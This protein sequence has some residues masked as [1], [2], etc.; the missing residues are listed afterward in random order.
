MNTLKLTALLTIFALCCSCSDSENEMILSSNCNVISSQT[1]YSLESEPYNSDEVA[2]EEFIQNLDSLNL[3]YSDSITIS[4]GG[5]SEITKNA[6]IVAADLVG[7]KAG[8][9]G[10]KWLGSVL[11]AGSGNP[12]VVALGYFGGKKVGSILGY[13]FA[14]ALTKYVLDRSLLESSY[15]M[16][17]GFVADCSLKPSVIQRQRMELDSSLYYDIPEDLITQSDS[18]G[19]YHNLIM[20]EI[21]RN[22][23]NLM[24][25]GEIDADKLYDFIVEYLYLRKIV[26]FEFFY[27]RDIRAGFKDLGQTALNVSWKAYGNGY[28]IEY[29]TSSHSTILKNKYRLDPNTEFPYYRRIN[30]LVINQCCQMQI[31]QIKSYAHELNTLILNSNMSLELKEEALYNCQFSVN[32]SLCWNQN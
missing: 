32:S 15:P 12:V 18:I 27:N 23:H 7:E 11:C 16:I 2:F 5:G 9:Y 10:G 19:Y 30:N 29:V 3:I 22:R 28:S 13:S 14:S 24:T 1:A 31:P 25:N 17:T 20:C 21:D 8:A 4:R 6:A 26:P